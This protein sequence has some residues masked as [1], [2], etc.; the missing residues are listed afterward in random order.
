MT[1]IKARAKHEAAKR[2]CAA[3][4]AW[5]EMGHWKFDIC[6]DPKKVKPI[7]A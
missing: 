3:V 6:K 2:W 5:V 7:L 4:S 1:K